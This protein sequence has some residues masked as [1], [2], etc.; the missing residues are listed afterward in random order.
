MSKVNRRSFMHQ[1]LSL[2]A[3]AIF[4]PGTM[5]LAQAIEPPT[6]T[7]YNGQHTHTTEALVK[8]FTQAT[9]VHV[10]VRKGSSAQLA[11]QIIEEGA[12]S[13]ADVFYAEESPPVA[14]L[15]NKGLLSV[16]DASTLTQIIPGYIA[17]NGTWISVSARSRA[18]AY[19]PSLLKASALPASIMDIATADWTGR[20]GFVPTSGAFQEQLIAIELLLGRPAA[21]NWLKDLKKYGRIYNGNMAAMKAVESGDIAT[22]LVNNYYWFAVAKEIGAD[23]MQSALHYMDH[24]DPGGLITVS[25]AGILKSSRRQALAQQFL[26]FMVGPAGQQAIVDSVAEYPLRPGIVSPFN[27]KPFSQLHPPKISPAD[28]G[29][30]ADALALRREAGLA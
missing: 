13:P 18:I 2:G 29:D 25:A 8:A 30:A 21:L 9:G 20:V 11:N 1:S 23:K 14:V 6:L 5:R 16:L 27:L 4:A 19:N 15:D 26:A 24:Q 12:R 10:D 28:L 17:K 3:A 22:A 7:L